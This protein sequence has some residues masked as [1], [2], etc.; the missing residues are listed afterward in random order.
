M[1]PLGRPKGSRNKRSIMREQR[2]KATEAAIQLAK[3][4]G[5]KIVIEDS[6]AIMEHAMRYF[7][8]QAL[9]AKVDDK[10]TIKTALLDAVAIASQVCNY[11]HPKLATVKVGGDRDN[12]LMVREG[13]TSK[14]IMEM[15]RQKMLETGLVPS[16]FVDL[17]PVKTDG[18]DGQASARDGHE[19]HG[20]VY[21]RNR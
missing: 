3:A 19:G 11:R 17:T 1:N 15:L 10:E 12:P 5:D 20:G 14:Q 8:T 6:L 4:N 21:G 16:Q 7:F 2:M 9:E 13:V 18:V